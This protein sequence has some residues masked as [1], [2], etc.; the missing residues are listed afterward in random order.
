M[1]DSYV[2]AFIDRLPQMDD[3]SLLRTL[4]RFTSSP[5]GY[6][7]ES[8]A[9]VRAE[10]AR[11]GLTWA[12]QHEAAERAAREAL[13]S[14]QEDAVDLA[15]E[16]RSEAGIQ[17]RLKARGLNEAAAATIARRAFDLPAEDQLHAGRRNMIAGGVICLVGVA[18]TAASCF[19][20]ATS[21]GGGTYVI[22]W[23]TVVVG[24]LWFLRGARQ[25]DRSSETIDEPVEPCVEWTEGDAARSVMFDTSGFGVVRR[26]PGRREWR[27]LHEDTMVAAVEPETAA[28]ASRALD[29]DALRARYRAEAAA[30]G[31]GIVS[32]DV[33]QAGGL[34]AVAV[35]SKFADGL[36]QVYEGTLVAPLRNA[37]LTVTLRA[38]ERRT[39]GIRE[40]ATVGHLLSL[41]LLRIPDGPPT[42][43]ARRMDDLLL[44]PYDPAQDGSAMCSLADDERLDELFPAHP[45]SKVRRW[46]R[47]VAETLAIDD[48]TRPVP[49][50]EVPGSQA[51]SRISKRIGPRAIGLLYLQAGKMA[52]AEALFAEAIAPAA[53]EPVLHGPETAD[54]LTLLGLA[55]EA[56]GKF[57]EADWAMTRAHQLYQEAVGDADIRTVRAMSNRARVSLPLGRF[58]EAGLLFEQAMPALT[59]HGTSGDVAVALNGL[60]LVRSAAGEHREAI[61]FFERALERFE[62]AEK[63]QGRP[64]SDRA[65]VLFNLAN[66]LDAIGD[67]RGASTARARARTAMAQTGVR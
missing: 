57:P 66:A 31:G 22:R 27:D 40:A 37:R 35:V 5:G 21:E 8:V 32:V 34:A 41:G 20:A 47:T 43:G 14:L 9:A 30:C 44:D 55:R 24:I 25:V 60:G 3:D 65:T 7:P 54:N 4:I 29:I 49:A 52:T 33:V 17:A 67:D 13:A 51:E 58:A 1:P 56:Q 26:A 50:L 10:V 46:L 18:M 15:L 36:A 63:E 59:A 11:R 45:L 48:A 23:G 64:I 53:G 2:K 38:R 62:Q 28:D 19:L 6:R 42:G 61:T 39:T 12:Q 16:G